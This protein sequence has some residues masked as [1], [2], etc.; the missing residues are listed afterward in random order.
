MSQR[1]N[2]IIYDRDFVLQHD[3]RV[4]DLSEVH[5]ARYLKL[6]A[7][8]ASLGREVL[9]EVYNTGDLGALR[10]A[11]KCRFR[12]PSLAETLR[13]LSET[14]PE[15]PLIRIRDGRIAV[16]GLA[17]RSTKRTVERC[18]WGHCIGSVRS[19]S[20]CIGSDRFEEERRAPAAPFT[21]A[22]D[23]APDAT[24]D[25]PQTISPKELNH[26]MLN[27]VA[28]SWRSRFGDTNAPTPGH[29]QRI[30][31][32]CRELD[33]APWWVID[34]AAKQSPENPIKYLEWLIKESNGDR[35]YPDE[36]GTSFAKWEADTCT[37]IRTG[38]PAR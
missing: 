15:K 31:G 20:D 18:D 21:D 19:G 22:H 4:Q 17:D 34:Y 5:H 12:R 3:W 24:P 14:P 11:L 26:A 8:A 28:A 16:V 32:R 10:R 37:S 2:T 33:V 7:L 9:P 38:Q 6:W 13:I 1:V 25:P 35:P 29:L 30:I 27:R 23:S 36:P